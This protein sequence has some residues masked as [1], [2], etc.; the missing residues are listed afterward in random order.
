[1]ASCE[2]MLDLPGSVLHDTLPPP[3][4]PPPPEFLAAIVAREAEQTAAGA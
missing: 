4:P 1:M 3:L 2:K